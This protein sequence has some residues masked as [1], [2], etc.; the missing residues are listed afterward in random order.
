MH[1]P[2]VLIDAPFV[3]ATQLYFGNSEVVFWGTRSHF[4]DVILQL[5]GVK[6]VISDAPRYDNVQVVVGGGF[7]WLEMVSYL[8]VL[9]IIRIHRFKKA[10]EVS[11]ILVDDGVFM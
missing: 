6:S 8:V 10:V 7:F 11:S 3:I 1:V 4:E 2:N 9:V 5:C